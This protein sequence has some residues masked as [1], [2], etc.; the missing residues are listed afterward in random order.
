VRAETKETLLLGAK[1]VLFSLGGLLV[2]ASL[3]D[4]VVTGPNWTAA[5]VLALGLLLAGPPLG[6]AFRDALRHARAGRPGDRG[7]S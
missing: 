7:R 2:V 4:L 5:G 1:T 6:L 3:V